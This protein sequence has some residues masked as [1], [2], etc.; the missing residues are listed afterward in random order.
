MR[1]GDVERERGGAEGAGKEGESGMGAGGYMDKY[2]GASSNIHPPVNV[3]RA[4]RG[5]SLLQRPLMEHSAT[6][7]LLIVK[8]LLSI[9]PIHHNGNNNYYHC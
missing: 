3:S 4:P 2:R 6:E 5:P 9:H 1:Q 8:P 7:H